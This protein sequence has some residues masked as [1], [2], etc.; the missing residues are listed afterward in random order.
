MIKTTGIGFTLIGLVAVSACNTETSKK[1]P[2]SAVEMNEGDPRSS[3]DMGMIPMLRQDAATFDPTPIGGGPDA[4]PGMMGQPDTSGTGDAGPGTILV[5]GGDASGLD[6]PRGIDGLRG[7][8]P[9]G[10]SM[11]CRGCWDATPARRT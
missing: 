1:R 5:L 7:L 11:A 3:R 9:C 6:M 8:M 10:G 4:R 2:D